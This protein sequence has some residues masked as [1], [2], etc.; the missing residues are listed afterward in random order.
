MSPPPDCA[1]HSFE[2]GQDDVKEEYCSHRSGLEFEEGEEAPEFYDDWNDYEEEYGEDMEDWESCCSS[3][4]GS[5]TLQ[6]WP[7]PFDQGT[8][9]S[10]APRSAPSR[11]LEPL[12]VH[13]WQADPTSLSIGLKVVC[14]SRPPV[15]SSEVPDTLRRDFELA[16]HSPQVSS[17]CECF[18][19]TFQSPGHIESAPES[20]P[21]GGNMSGDF[22]VCPDAYWAA[23]HQRVDPSFLSFVGVSC[24]L[25]CQL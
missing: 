16:P 9:A 11:V 12:S 7:D 13:W 3:S 1:A 2:D 19:E 20:L 25:I 4:E 8:E 17:Y 23:F 21:A 22:R 10:S 14:L 15:K 24:F 5:E 6:V 18:E